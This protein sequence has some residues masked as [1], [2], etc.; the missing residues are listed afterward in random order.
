[1][2]APNSRSLDV[3]RRS[4]PILSSRICLQVMDTKPLRYINGIHLFFFFLIRTQNEQQWSLGLNFC[5]WTCWS[6]CSLHCRLSAF[7]IFPT[8]DKIKAFFVCPFEIFRHLSQR[9]H[10][11]WRYWREQTLFCLKWFLLVQFWLLSIPLPSHGLQT[12]LSI[13][14]TSVF[15]MCTRHWMH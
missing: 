12:G 8:F 3:H 7:L 14:K 11:S 13:N 5:I 4:S 2:V 6:F 15:D 9:M 10:P 1:M